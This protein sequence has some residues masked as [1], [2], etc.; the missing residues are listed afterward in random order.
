M[1]LVDMINK[2]LCFK[3][4][5]Q[6]KTNR[7]GEKLDIDISKLSPNK[8][9]VTE[10]TFKVNDWDFSHHEHML[11]KTLQNLMISGSFHFST[12]LIVMY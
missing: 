7:T 6:D 2:S 3:A 8:H 4:Y 11:L 5:I 10:D 1:S 12:K 9:K